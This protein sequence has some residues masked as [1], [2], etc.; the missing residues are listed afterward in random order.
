MPGV[1]KT[2]RD[3]RYWIFYQTLIKRGIELEKFGDERFGL[4]WTIC[5]TG[6]NSKSVVYSAGIGGDIS[7]EQ[8][9][10]K[11]FGCDIILC[12][13]S[14]IAAKTMVLPENR[15][16]QFHFRPLALAG[17]TGHIGV[18][19][20]TDSKGET[21]FSRNAED[22]GKQI[23]CMDV[24]SLMESNGHTHIDLIK[25]D[26]EGSEYDVIEDMVKRRIPARQI[27]LE[28][29]H[30]VLPGITRMQSIRSMFKLFSRG[31][32]M[33]HQEGCNHTFILMRGRKR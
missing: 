2:F 15:I 4:Q 20:Q 25:I 18:S 17:H 8:A 12:D 14:P 3:V 23:A 1:A 21:W 28:Y 22:M 16:P 29:H 31:Y 30:G 13:P 10:V 9:L 19:P 26:I 33:V 5:P 11:R 6:L 7:F 24:A 27:C 32:R